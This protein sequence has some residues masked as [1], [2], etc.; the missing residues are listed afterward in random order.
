MIDNS[1]FAAPEV[2]APNLDQGRMKF[3]GAGVNSTLVDCGD[4]HVDLSDI[5]GG[6]SVGEDLQ[7]V[8]THSE[9]NREGFFIPTV[10][11]LGMK[12][13]P[14]PH[15]ICPSG[16]PG[17]PNIN[18]VGGEYFNSGVLPTEYFLPYSNVLSSGANCNTTSRLCCR[19][20][21]YAEPPY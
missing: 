18:E 6:D 17:L 15:T 21:K 9:R 4:L 20:P 1:V 10:T 8:F 16:Q 3:T 19:T 12:F 11:D 14:K 5:D 7:M 13:F 2:S